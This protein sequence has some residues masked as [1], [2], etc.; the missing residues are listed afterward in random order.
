MSYLEIVCLLSKPECM[1]RTRAE[2]VIV[3]CGELLSEISERLELG[4]I[5]LKV[6]SVAIQAESCM[7]RCAFS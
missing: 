4:R 7:F 3:I 2:V 1:S 5:F 6:C